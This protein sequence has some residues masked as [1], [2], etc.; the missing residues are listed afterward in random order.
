MATLILLYTVSK[1]PGGLGGLN[2]PS[3]FLDPPP[4]ILNIEPLG[5]SRKPP[6]LLEITYL[7]TLG[8]TNSSLKLSIKIYRTIR[9]TFIEDID[10]NAK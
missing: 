5:G 8:L 1:L 9:P 7:V 10:H 3:Y 2:P 6:Q 4:V